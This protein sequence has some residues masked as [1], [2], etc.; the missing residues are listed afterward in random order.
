ML[1]YQISTSGQKL[2]AAV[3]HT[4]CVLHIQR[5]MLEVLCSMWL[6]E[7]IRTFPKILRIFLKPLWAYFFPVPHSELEEKKEK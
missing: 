3:T 5:H 4:M 2:N 6:R 1:K 7:S